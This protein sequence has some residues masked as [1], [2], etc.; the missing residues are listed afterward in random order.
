MNSV[1]EHLKVVNDVTVWCTHLCRL[2]FRRFVRGKRWSMKC[3]QT[4]SKGSMAR[5]VSNSYSTCRHTVY[6]AIA[7]SVGFGVLDHWRPDMINLI[8][9]IL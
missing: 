4:P 6:S 5:Y 2:E 8:S 3:C 9:I 1:N 7:R